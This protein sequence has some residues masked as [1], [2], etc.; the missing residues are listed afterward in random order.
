MTEIINRIKRGERV[1]HYET[2]RRHKNGATLHV[3][4]T[5]SPIYDADGRLIGASKVSRDISAAKR[6]EAA[7]TESQTRL[8]ELHSEL[9]HVSRLSAMG[10]MAAMVTHELN[11]PL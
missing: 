5:V 9:L 3:S 7:L 4:L 10:Q 6:A 1:D 11:Q 8:Q 2:M